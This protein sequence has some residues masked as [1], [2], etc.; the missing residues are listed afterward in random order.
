MSVKK[1]H[2]EIKLPAFPPRQ[3]PYIVK[4][5]VKVLNKQKTDV[6]S[7]AAAEKISFSKVYNWISG[8]AEPKRDSTEAILR[9]FKR[10]KYNYTP[11]P[12]RKNAANNPDNKLPAINRAQFSKS[13]PGMMKEIQATLNKHSEQVILLNAQL[14]EIAEKVDNASVDMKALRNFLARKKEM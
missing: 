5:L 2:R 12:L 13:V 11:K 14:R 7:F 8:K 1:K 6:R 9:Y 10:I 3:I 4:E